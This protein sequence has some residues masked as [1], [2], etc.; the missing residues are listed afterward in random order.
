[1]THVSFVVGRGKWL[2]V[3]VALAG[4]LGALGYGCSPST[5]AP[6]QP[7]PK[8]SGAALPAASL[9]PTISSAGPNAPPPPPAEVGFDPKTVLLVLD[10][11]AL[12]DVKAAVQKEA[13]VRAV[14]LLQAKVAQN[15]DAGQKASWLYQLGKLRALAGDPL[16][17][18]KAYEECA[19][20]EHLLTDHARF[21]AADIYVKANKDAKA[22]ALLSQMKGTLGIS[23]DAE[24]VRAAAMEGTGDIEGASV[25]WR[26]FLNRK[27]R[28]SSWVNVTLKFAG[29]LLKHPTD[30]HNEE[31][32]KLARTILEGSSS[33]GLGEAKEMETKGLG[34]LPTKRRKTLETPN[35]EELF[36]KAKRL[37]GSGQVKE[38]ATILETL[39]KPLKMPKTKERICDL[40]LLIGDNNVKS[41]RKAEAADA[42]EEAVTLCKETPRHVEALFN[43]GKLLTTTGRYPQGVKRFEELEASYSNHRLAD[44]ARYKRA[45]AAL[46][47][48]DDV[49]FAK[50]LTSLPDDYPAGDMVNDGLFELALYYVERKQ[51]AASMVPLFR[52]VTIEKERRERVYYSA[53]RFGYF[54]GRALIETA[55]ESKGREHLTSVIQNYPLTYYSALAYARLAERDPNVAKK[56]LD[57][58]L[59]QEN[60]EPFYVP[61]HPALKSAT[62]ARAIELVKQGEAKLARAELDLLGVS[63]RTAPREV[64]WAAA[65]L[66]AQVGSPTQSHGVL[67]SAAVTTSASRTELSEWLEH[68]PAGK[69]RSA[70]EL[71]FP[72]P[73][74]EVVGPAAAQAGI[75]ESLAYAIMREESGFDPRAV[76]PAKA[77]GLMQLIVPTAKRMAKPLG[78]PHD[79][80]SLKKPQVNIP[81]GCRYLG[82]LRQQFPDNPALSIPGYN[83]GGGAP[84][85][86]LTERAGYDFDVWVERIPYDETQKYTK[87]VLGTM[88]AYEL[89]YWP[90]KPTEARATPKAAGTVKGAAPV[91]SGGQSVAPSEPTQPPSAGAPSVADVPE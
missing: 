2:G 59:S 17:A 14:E 32:V 37:S 40:K 5:S 84:K 69:W 49:T 20:T 53:G 87:R 19:A 73:F 91:M 76:S 45:L 54:L 30:A 75:P 71:S 80:E 3:G 12:S 38:A 65:L 83:A 36:L 47:N 48:Q 57:E 24:L 60:T 39:S 35:A 79:T 70:W 16:G 81:L 51:W 58:A 43:A 62:F 18:A 77:Y 89:L 21:Q 50:L 31:A 27:P 41:K 22:L 11:P 63:D 55:N 1:M 44:D 46:A 64:L 13:F 26:E 15:T 29:A 56:V 85:K 78:L 9:V 88:A 7:S 42:Y 52:A 10:E 68:H 61:A 4:L 82:Q 67:R 6:K 90:D 8:P 25:V 72:R 34:L 66:F 23:A 86:W 28:P 33:A 74:A